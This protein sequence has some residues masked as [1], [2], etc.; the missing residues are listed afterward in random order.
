MCVCVLAP[1]GTAPRLSALLAPPGVPLHCYPF[2]TGART[3]ALLC[4]CTASLL[5]IAPI[6]PAYCI[7]AKG[8]P[9][10]R[11]AA[12]SYICEPPAY[13]VASQGALLSR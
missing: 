11:A 6:L 3:G 7:G 1:P 8:E 5:Y 2:Y 4:Y 12:V 10:G 13:T 9:R